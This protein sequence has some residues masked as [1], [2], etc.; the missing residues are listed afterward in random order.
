M[1]L[2]AKN[3]KDFISP[4]RC[5][6]QDTIAILKQ[7]NRVWIGSNW[8]E[9]P[10]ATCPRAD[11]PSGVGYELCHDVCKQ[12]GHAEVDACRKA[13]AEAKGATLY[14]IGHTYCCDNCK[15]VMAEHGVA[16]VVIGEYPDVDVNIVD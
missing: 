1:K 11:M 2:T 5:A 14:L 12:S 15:R 10:Q 13:G 7:G 4:N 8:C 9:C 6:K 16:H 3:I